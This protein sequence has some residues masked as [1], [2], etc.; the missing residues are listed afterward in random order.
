MTL[1]TTPTQIPATLASFRFDKVP[2]AGD[3]TMSL[4]AAL[5]WNPEQAREARIWWAGLWTQAARVE[6]TPEHA[7]RYVDNCNEAGWI[8]VAGRVLA[9]HPELTAWAEAAI[10]ATAPVPAA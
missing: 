6:T 3:L 5:Y 4:G 8:D 9:S 1:T 10:A 7:A 2:P